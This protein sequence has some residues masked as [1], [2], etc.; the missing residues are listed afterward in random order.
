MFRVALWVI[1][2][3]LLAATILDWATIS[4]RLSRFG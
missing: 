4:A 3:A 1:V 2:A